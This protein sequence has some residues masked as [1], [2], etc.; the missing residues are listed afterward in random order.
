MGN[1]IGVN[2]IHVAGHARSEGLIPVIHNP[3]DF[4]KVDALRMVIWA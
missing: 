1:P 2:D 3:G 4:E